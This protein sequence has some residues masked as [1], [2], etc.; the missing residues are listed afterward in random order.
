MTRGVF[1][2]R[3][4]LQRSSG[5]AVPIPRQ[6]LSRASPCVDDWIIYYE[7]RRG[8]IGKGYHAIAK[9]DR[10]VPD[11]STAGM[12]LALI[13][14]GSYLPFE[15]AVPSSDA[16]GVVD[17]RCAITGLKFKSGTPGCGS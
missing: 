5:G 11:P 2:Q 9:V 8:P 6:Y 7:P 16:E 14:P 17:S 4:D 15:R 13:E 1:L 12:H 10:I 3:L